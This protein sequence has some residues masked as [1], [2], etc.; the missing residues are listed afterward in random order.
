[1]LTDA[2]WSLSYL[3]DGSIDRIQA[4]VNSGV[5]RRLVELLGKGNNMVQ[6]PVL[7]TLGN[8]A[9][10]DDHQTQVILKAG[11]LQELTK[12]LQH[13]KKTLRKESAWIL[14][15]ITAGTEEQIQQVQY[16]FHRLKPEE[17]EH[18]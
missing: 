15:N 6:T 4:V 13:P 1:M 3:S 10:G 7:R 14:S 18:F 9:T 16:S 17:N 11:V 2:C 8:I 5:C 12:L